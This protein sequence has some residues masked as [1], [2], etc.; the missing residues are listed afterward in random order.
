[1][2]ANYA[3]IWTCI[4]PTVPEA[5]SRFAI[6]GSAPASITFNSEVPLS[7]SAGMPQLLIYNASPSIVATLTAAS[8]ASDG[9]SATFPYPASLPP[10]AYGTQLLNKIGPNSSQPAGFNFLSVA[11][12]QVFAG[13]PFGIAV[14]GQTD[15]YEDRDTCDRTDDSGS[16]YFTTFVVSLYSQGLVLVGGQSVTV[17][18][19]PTAVAAYVGPSTAQASGDECDEDRDVYSGQTRAIVTNSGSNSV[20]ILDLV[21]DNA[22]LTLP[23]GE[24]PDAVVVS[25]NGSAAYVANYGSSTVTS[26]NLSAGTVGTTVAVGGQ[27]TS[28]ALSAS[29]TLWVGGVGFL[30]EINTNTMTVVTTQVIPGKSIIGLAYSDLQNQ[31][32]AT[33]SDASGNV[34][35]EQISPSSV[36]AGKAYSPDVSN[37]VSSLALHYDALA[38]TNVQAFTSTMANSGSLNPNQTGAPPLVVQDGWVAITATPTG[39]TVTDITSGQVLISEKTPSPVAAIAVDPNLN[40]AYLTLPD[41]N[42]LLTVPLPGVN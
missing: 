8:V 28:V 9:S 17:G 7:T 25:S 42:V 23:V 6:Y 40:V 38:R 20:S 19:N 39:F 3:W 21:N 35:S 15:A 41:S 24:Q 14:A 12:Q 4:R 5:S 30:T 13:T 10:G 22:V 36:A 37:K 2:T 18:T 26:I 16:S 33:T 31:V 29:G 27:P 34:Y 1:M 32:V 11:Q